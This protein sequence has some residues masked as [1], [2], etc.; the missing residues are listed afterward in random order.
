MTV[1]S[2]QRG[3][4]T[5]PAAG[6]C[7]EGAREGVTNPRFRTDHSVESRSAQAIVR[8]LSRAGARDA[9]KAR[10]LFHWLRRV[11]FHSGPEEPLRHD[12]NRMINVFGYGSCYL[13]THPLS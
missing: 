12:F 6:S 5:P 7:T 3:N 11:I 2:G 13:Q 10:G 1:N 9:K 4:V 8:D